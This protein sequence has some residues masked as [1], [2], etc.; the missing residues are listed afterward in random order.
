VDK[1]AD[2]DEPGAGALYPTAANWTEYLTGGY[3]GDYRTIA[4][5]T[6]GASAVWDFGTQ[7]NPTKTYQVF[8]TWPSG[9]DRAA[10]ARFELR[11]GTNLDLYK[12]LGI[13]QQVGP[14]DYVD[15]N[16]VHWQRLDLVS[17]T[18]KF[19][20]TLNAASS[21]GVTGANLVVADA[22]QVVE[23]GPVDMVEYDAAGQV[24]QTTDA[25][26]H[27]TV[28]KYDNTGRPIEATLPDPDF[29]PGGTNGPLLSPVYKT[30]YDAAA[31]VTSTTDPMGS[32]TYYEYDNRNRGTQVIEPLADPAATPTTYTLDEP[33]NGSWLYSSGYGGFAGDF[34]HRAPG[35]STETIDWTFTVATGRTYQLLASWDVNGLATGGFPI[36]PWATDA[37]FEVF[38]NGVSKALYRV[39]QQYAPQD[40]Q[41]D[42]VMWQ[43]LGVMTPLNS[44]VTVKLRA[45]ANGYL[46]ADAV[47]FVEVGGVSKT[48]FDANG[49]VTGT[50]DQLDRRTQY[51]HDKINRTIEVLQP[52][53]DGMGQ[54]LPPKTN[55]EYDDNGNVRYEKIRLTDSPVVYL[56]TEH[57]YDRLNREIRGI[58]AERAGTGIGTSYTYDADGRPTQITDAN[59][60]DTKF[61]YNAL[62][63]LTSET[64]EL[65]KVRSFEYDANGQLRKT[66]LRNAT[67]SIEYIYD[68]LGRQLQR[69]SVTCPD[70]R[71][72]TCTVPIRIRSFSTRR[73]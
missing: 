71:I 4:A 19:S 27:V 20:V 57:Q 35:L 54:K 9:T 45:D 15:A 39:N 11:K 42:G 33:S 69:C 38:E 47:K 40:A 14:S 44:S 29:V 41:L 64:N 72:G 12:T 17:G 60:N 55:L 7:L 26:G 43:R 51:A 24:V 50:V 10:D 58:D 53:P 30:T 32:V 23:V 66:S 5:G 28:L 16:G 68:R 52:D 31:N 56:T 18:S 73:Q 49:N 8:M 2:E 36:G 48:E 70:V 59:G 63:Q 22:I 65:N 1:F 67:Q 13:N 37:P 25:L 46:N 21:G 6:A 61:A 3:G 34:R 62:G